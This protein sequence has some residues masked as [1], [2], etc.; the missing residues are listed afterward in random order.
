LGWTVEITAKARKT[1]TGLDRSAVERINHFIRERLVP[2]EN[3][4]NL[5]KALKGPLG[6]FWRYRVGDYRLICCIEDK[7][8]TILA[9]KI[10]HRREA[11]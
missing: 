3:P 2:S 6:D 7:R 10:S 9:V 11:Y 4:R 5:G 8:M 1:L